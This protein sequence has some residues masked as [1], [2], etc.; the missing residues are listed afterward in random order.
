M[1]H[2]SLVIK[3]LYLCIPIAEFMHLILNSVLAIHSDVTPVQALYPE[4]GS[5]IK[6]RE[7]EKKK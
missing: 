5:T 1:E 3:P 6:K 2:Y 4:D 7:R